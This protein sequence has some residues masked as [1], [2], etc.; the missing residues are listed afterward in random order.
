MN[1]FLRL[2][3]LMGPPSCLILGTACSDVWIDPFADA[4]GG[5]AG[6]A[7]PRG[8]AGATAPVGGAGGTWEQGGGPEGGGGQTGSDRRPL[9]LVAQSGGV[10]LWDRADHIPGDVLPSATLAGLT[11]TP[12][13]LARRGDD[14]VVYTQGD[15]PVARI[16][17]F[18]DI[19]KYAGAGPATEETVDTPTLLGPTYLADFQI[20]TSG[21]MF[22]EHVPLLLS[23][24]PDDTM[25]LQW[26]STDQGSEPA[27]T[28]SQWSPRFRQFAFSED[29]STVFAG[30]LAGVQRVRVVR[31]E[32][33]VEEGGALGDGASDV[34]VARFGHD[35][36]SVTQCHDS[37]GG[38]TCLDPH[39]HVWRDIGDGA[40]VTEPDLDIP[41]GHARVPCDLHVGEAGIFIAMCSGLSGPTGTPPEL[42]WLPPPSAIDSSSNVIGAVDLSHEPRQLAVIPA[43]PNVDDAPFTVFVRCDDRL[44]VAKDFMGQLTVTEEM[45]NGISTTYDMLLLP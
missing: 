12:R 37:G 23:F 6:G 22:A 30:S 32:G 13:G 20:D 42:V 35:L 5:G 31:D 1:G 7:E 8:G 16:V 21:L 43:D 41:L 38:S 10:A 34:L 4:G 33:R 18:T 9:L 40:D 11:S 3:S 44:V 14:L 19:G 24:N 36:F 28:T 15:T 25:F 27:W 17:T 39:L 29:D 45:V 2:A 26:Q